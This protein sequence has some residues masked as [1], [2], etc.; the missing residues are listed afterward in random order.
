MAKLVLC[1]T[2]LWRQE[3]R[4]H[5]QHTAEWQDIEYKGYDSIRLGST[6]IHHLLNDYPDILTVKNIAFDY[7]IDKQTRLLLY[8][9]DYDTAYNYGSIESFTK[10]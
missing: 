7:A 2:K 3:S 5:V 6:H 1:N 4:M 9:N 8:Q 10:A